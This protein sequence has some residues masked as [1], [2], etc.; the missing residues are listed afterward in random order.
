VLSKMTCTFGKHATLISLERQ[1]VAVTA[2]G[3]T[4]SRW[5]LP[6]IRATFN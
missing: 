2:A 3:P 6:T 4:P 5:D 1:V